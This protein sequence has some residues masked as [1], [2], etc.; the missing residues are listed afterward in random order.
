MAHTPSPASPVVG[1]GAGRERRPASSTNIDHPQPGTAGSVQEPVD[2]LEHVAQ[3]LA[4]LSKDPIKLIG[5]KS[6]RP[7][8]HAASSQ[9]MPILPSVRSVERICHV[10]GRHGYG[11][12]S[13]GPGPAG[14]GGGA[15]G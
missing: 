13:A 2:A 5:I 10:G 15:G 4:P 9:L 8:A 1:S 14:G 11:A 12:G 6:E 3:S 7:V